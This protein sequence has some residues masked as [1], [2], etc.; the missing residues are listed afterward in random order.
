MTLWANEEISEETGLPASRGVGARRVSGLGCGRCGAASAGPFPRSARLSS[1][2][3]LGLAVLPVPGW[4][5]AGPR[6]GHGCERRTPC[7]REASVRWDPGHMWDW[8]CLSVALWFAPK[9]ILIKSREIAGVRRPC[10][11]NTRAVIFLFCQRMSVIS[12]VFCF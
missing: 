9:P 5:C 12:H 10:Y 2:F 7:F 1:A 8:R 11:I 4:S 3:A 6:R